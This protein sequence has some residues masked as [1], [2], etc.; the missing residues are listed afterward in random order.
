MGEIASNS[1]QGLHVL[2][3]EDNFILSELVRQVLVD[4]HCSVIGPID[5]LTGTLAAIRSS[6]HIDGALL[7]VQLG[8]ENIL[9]AAQELA[10]RGVP[11]I[12]TT[13]HAN[14][15]GLPALLANAPL[16]TKP[17]DLQG[18]QDMM[19]STFGRGLENGSEAV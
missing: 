17:F 6:K 18:L 14:L 1:F 10:L 2:V 16:L 7:D 19:K 3:A 4:L 8:E 11:F 15:V 9:P 12:L 5:D 13:G